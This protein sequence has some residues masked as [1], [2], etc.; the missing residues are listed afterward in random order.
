MSSGQ[1]EWTYSGLSCSHLR[2]RASTAHPTLMT[3]PPASA[4]ASAASQTLPAPPSMP[5]FGKPTSQWLTLG[6]Q[7][8]SI[9]EATLGGTSSSS[10]KTSNLLT[11]TYKSD[12][13]TQLSKQ[14]QVHTTKIVVYIYYVL[15]DRITPRLNDSRP[16]PRPCYFTSKASEV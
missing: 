6:E 16:K 14:L 10:T 8:A 15:S 9:G 11:W 13:N 2:L 3:Q 4:S 1:Q 7:P 12:G 5:N